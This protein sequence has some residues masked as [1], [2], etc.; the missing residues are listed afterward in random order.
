MRYR[1]FLLFNALGGLVWGVGFTLIGYA[2]GNAYSRIEHFVGRGAA[3]LLVALIVV[4]LA[5][6]HVRRHRGDSGDGGTGNDH[7]GSDT[8]GEPEVGP[9]DGTGTAHHDD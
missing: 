4:L 5:V 7:G 8:S 2:A 6:R 3:L 9:A 1:T